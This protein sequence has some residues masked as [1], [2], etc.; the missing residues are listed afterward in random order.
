MTPTVIAGRGLVAGCGTRLER[1]GEGTQS[2]QSSSG[3]NTEHCGAKHL[4]LI[5]PESRAIVE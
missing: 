3:Q 5:F 2:T 4:L 1:A